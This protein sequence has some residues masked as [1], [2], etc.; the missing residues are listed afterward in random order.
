MPNFLVE[1]YIYL[2]LGG[3]RYFESAIPPS[4]EVCN[5]HADRQI[6]PP[7]KYLE[8]EANFKLVGEFCEIGALIIGGFDHFNTAKA[9]QNRAA[10]SPFGIDPILSDS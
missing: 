7:Y 10:I 1:C 4:F 3:I 9:L 6:L 2:V 5:P 8:F